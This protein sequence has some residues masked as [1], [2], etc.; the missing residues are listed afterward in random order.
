MV[1]PP[2][3]ATGL[4]FTAREAL[5]GSYAVPASRGSPVAEGNALKADVARDVRPAAGPMMTERPIDVVPP[6]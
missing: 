5:A 4:I 1:F 6:A 2:R 3:P